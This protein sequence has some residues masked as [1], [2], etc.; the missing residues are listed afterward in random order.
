MEAADLA[1]RIAGLGGITFAIFVIGSEVADS[2]RVTL[3]GEL[4]RCRRESRRLTARL[5]QLE[6]QAEAREQDLI[7]ALHADPCDCR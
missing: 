5:K 6:E 7:E 2:V 1:L 3:L 4:T